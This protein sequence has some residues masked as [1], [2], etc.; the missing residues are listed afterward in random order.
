VS[1][2]L[3]LDHD[4]EEAELEFELAYLRGL[5]VQERFALMFRR[6]TEIATTLLRHGYRKPVDV[7]KRQ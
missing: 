4:D 6:S 7:V 5:T 2:V 1:T 3:K